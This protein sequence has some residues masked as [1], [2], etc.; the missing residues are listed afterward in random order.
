V[1]ADNRSGALAEMIGKLKQA[2]IR[3]PGGFATTAEAYWT[4]SSP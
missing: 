4:A 3:V 1:Q 2:G